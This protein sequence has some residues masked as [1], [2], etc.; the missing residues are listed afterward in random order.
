VLAAEMVKQLITE[1]LMVPLTV[2]GRHKRH[3]GRTVIPFTDGYHALHALFLAR[4]LEP[5][6]VRIAVRR[7][8]GCPDPRH[9]WGVQPVLNGRAP[10]AVSIAD[11][12]ARADQLGAHYI[13]ERRHDLR[14]NLFM[15]MQRRGHALDS[16]RAQLD[17]THGVVV[18]ADN[19]RDLGQD[20]APQPRAEEGQGVAVP[21]RTDARV[22][23]VAAPSDP[24]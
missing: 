13:G 23:R 24:M 1:T 9:V 17:H 14:H 15:R 18:R 19:G 4:G 11:P 10:R 21:R 22:G 2:M 3:E 7:D 12:H 8:D 16:L 20:R 6:R 5:R